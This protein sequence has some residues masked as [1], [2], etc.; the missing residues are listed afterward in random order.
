MASVAGVPVFLMLLAGGTHLSVELE[1]KLTLQPETMLLF[2]KQGGEALFV[3]M[4][5]KR[6]QS[7]FVAVLYRSTTDGYLL[8]KNTSQVSL[9]VGGDSLA[10]TLK[11]QSLSDSGDYVIRRWNRGI[12]KGEIKYSLIDC[13][14]LCDINLWDNFSSWILKTKE[15]GDRLQFYEKCLNFTKFP[16]LAQTTLVLDSELPPDVPKKSDQRGD[17][18]MTNSSTTVR[19]SKGLCDV[20][21]YL[22]IW[23]GNPCCLSN[24]WVSIA[25]V[26]GA[27]PPPSSTMTPTHI[28]LKQRDRL[29]MPCPR[30]SEYV[31][32]V[33]WETPGS[34]LYEDVSHA[35]IQVIIDA[36]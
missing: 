27:S 3:F 15:T 26:T 36:K 25:A 32:E 5:A 9:S 35:I 14:K 1:A 17:A 8:L 10:F 22:L 34:N 4:S 21:L 29:I 6:H 31:E 24:Y 11:D 19:I 16:H 2:G 12:L 33:I 18:E 20:Y 28:L 13:K 7:S 30:F 23:R